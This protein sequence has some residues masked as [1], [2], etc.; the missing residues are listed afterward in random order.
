MTDRINKRP[1][2]NFRKI[3]FRQS[4]HFCPGCFSPKTQYIGTLPYNATFVKWGINPSVLSEAIGINSDEYFFHIHCC[5]DCSLVFVINNYDGLADYVEGQDFFLQTIVKSWAE[6]G[7]PFIDT[8]FVNK[9]METNPKM[10]DTWSLRYKIVTDI[11][12]NLSFETN[13]QSFLDLG[14]SLGSMTEFVRICFP[15]WQVHACELNRFAI[16]IF[17]ERYPHIPLYSVTLSNMSLFQKYDVIYCCDVIE[18]I[19]DMDEFMKSVILHLKPRGYIIFITPNIE[20]ESAQKQEGNWWGY[21]V[22]HHAQLFS[23][24]SIELMAQRFGLTKVAGGVFT[25]EELWMAFS[26]KN[27]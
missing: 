23:L 18:H 14:S 10:L 7:H 24:K 21:I 15:E 1:V 13:I 26:Y 11:L 12:K 8:G 25:A 9:I 2:V 27:E 5:K 19:W 4:G 17:E 16:K 3:I 6:N 22:P 20:C